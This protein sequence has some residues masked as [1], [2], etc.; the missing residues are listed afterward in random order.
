MK[1]LNILLLILIFSNAYSQ[2]ILEKEVKNYK[3]EEYGH[4]LAS[5]TG[6]AYKAI[7]I[8]EFNENDI[9]FAEENLLILSAFVKMIQ[10]GISLSPM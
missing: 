2:E 5:Y 1:T 8:Q 3:N 6:I 9:N 7:K 10:K 4:A